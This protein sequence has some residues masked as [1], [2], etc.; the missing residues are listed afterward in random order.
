MKKNDEGPIRG[1]KWR[2]C[3]V[4]LKERKE[5]SILDQIGGYLPAAV[6]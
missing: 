4:N 5:T 2:R 1:V 6:L 3:T